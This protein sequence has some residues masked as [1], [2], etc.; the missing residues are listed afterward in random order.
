MLGRIQDLT[1][2]HETFA[3]ETTLAT[4]SYRSKIIAAQ[5][6]GY[7][8]TLLFFWLQS[9]ELAI[10]RVRIRVLEGGHHIEPEVIKR[11]YSNGIHNLFTMY[12]PIVDDIQIYDNSEGRHELIAEKTLGFELDVLNPLKFNQLLAQFHETT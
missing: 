5:K 4:K 11:R 10:E 12:L 9:V 2:N 1:N 7:H 3:F 8:V 6:S